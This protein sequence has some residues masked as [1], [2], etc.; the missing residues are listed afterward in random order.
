VQRERK[1][2]NKE[3]KQEGKPKSNQ[4]RHG[5][6]EEEEEEEEHKN[7]RNKKKGRKEFARFFCCYW[8]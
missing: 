8:Y 3:N 7:G 5:E 6:E 1:F 4:I 2:R